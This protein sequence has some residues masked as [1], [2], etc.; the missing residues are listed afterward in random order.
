MSDP[1]TEESLQPSVLVTRIRELEFEKKICVWNLD[2]SSVG[3]FAV[4][5]F[6]VSS[7]TVK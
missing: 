6:N 7:M 5:C 4:I 2:V 1:F 3:N